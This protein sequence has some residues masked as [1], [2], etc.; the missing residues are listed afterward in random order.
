MEIKYG[1]NL[2]LEK[3]ALHQPQLTTNRSLNRHLNQVAINRQLTKV[4]ILEKMENLL[5]FQ[6]LA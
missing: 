5:F 4:A 1:A 3:N 6:F 2:Y